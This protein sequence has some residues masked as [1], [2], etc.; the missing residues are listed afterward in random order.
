MDG[1]QVSAINFDARAHLP[2]PKGLHHSLASSHRHQFGLVKDN[3][4]VRLSQASHL[5]LLTRGTV[6]VD[7]GRHCVADNS[8][9]WPVPSLTPGLI[10]PVSAWQSPA[11]GTH[12]PGAS[13]PGSI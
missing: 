7:Y 3:Y 1:G 8:F 12:R 4:A 11:R 6:V 10:R 5:E 13:R 2:Q 9:A